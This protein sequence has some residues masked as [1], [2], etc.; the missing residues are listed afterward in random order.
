[1][2]HIAFSA[3]VVLCNALLRLPGHRFRI[4]V[5][6]LIVR[7]EIEDGCAVERNVRITTKGGLAIGANTNINRGCLLDGRGGLRIGRRVNISSDVRLLTAEHDPDSPR[8][9]GRVGAVVVGDSVWIALGAMIL[10]G[11]CIEEGALV[12]AAA[13]V[14]GYVPARTIVAG[15]PAVAVG[16]RAP[17]AQRELPSYRRFMH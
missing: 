15:N 9:A 14:R 8:F 12:A 1:M 11:A 2:D 13:V 16:T 4:A 10:P 3:Y 5:L 7:A 6:R 17:D